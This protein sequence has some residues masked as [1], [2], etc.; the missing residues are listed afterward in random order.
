MAP[1]KVEYTEIF[2]NNSFHKSVSGKTFPVLNP[3]TEEKIADVQEGDKADVDKAVAAAKAAFKRG[4]TWRTMDASRRGQLLHKLAD[5]VERDLDHLV[6]LET[7]DNGKPLHAARGD[8][9]WG[10]GKLRHFAGWADKISG[11]TIPVDGK[12]FSFTRREPVGVVGCILPW[13]FPLMLMLDRLSVTL[14]CGCTLVVKPAEQT[15]L[16]ALHLAQLTKEAGFPDGV[17]GVV[18][19]YGPTAGAALSSHHDV[20]KVRDPDCGWAGGEEQIQGS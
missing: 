6:A 5:L 16:T 14:A 2:I 19:G 9:Q 17:L 13:N 1:P 20:R 11:Q 8:I 3:A 10:V 18:P 15:P 4:S 12:L 7:L